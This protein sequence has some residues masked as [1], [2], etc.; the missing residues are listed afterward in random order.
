MN[1]PDLAKELY[2]FGGRLWTA[3]KLSNFLGINQKAAERIIRKL[4]PTC[5]KNTGKRYYY[6]DVADLIY[7]GW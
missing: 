2:D 1:R 7:R 5:G 4:P 3:T 6:T